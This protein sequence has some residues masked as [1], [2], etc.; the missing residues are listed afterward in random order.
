MRKILL[1]M[2]FL[3]GMLMY[4]LPTIAQEKNVSGTV[5]DNDDNTALR[6]VTVTVKGT[7][8]ATK[9]NQE[10]FYNIQASKGQVLVFTFIGYARKELTVGD[11]SILNATLSQSDKALSEVV[12]TAYGIKKEKA[13]LSYSTV[14]IKGEDIA[15]T[16]RENF[17]NSLAGRVPGATITSTSGAPGASAQIILRG[18]VSIDGDN[19]PLFVVDG[20]PYDNQSL[21]QESLVPASN[22]NGIGFANRN[23]DYGN[24]A[25]DINPD[26]IENVTI[27]KGP[28]ATALYGAAGASGVIIITTKK[29]AKGKGSI[30]Y[31]NT[32][33]YEKVYRFPE[34]QTNFGRGRNGVSDPTSSYYFGPKYDDGTQL[35]DNFGAFLKTGITQ[36]HNLSIE[37]GSDVNTFRFSTGYTKQDGVIPTSAFE[38]LSFR[39]SGSSKL[40]PKLNIS[41]TANYVNSVTDK[42]SKGLGSYFLTLLSWPKDNDVRDYLNSDGSRK[43]LKGGNTLSETDNPF[44]DVNKNLANDRTDRFTFN[45]TISYDVLSWLNLTSNIGADVYSTQ[46]IYSTNPQSRY[47][48]ATNGFMS[49]YTQNTRNLSGNV[50]AGVKKNFDHISNSLIVGFNFDDNRTRIESQK[51]E[52]FIEPDFLS[53]NNVAPLTVSSKTTVLNFKR[54]RWF[55]S[56]TAGYDKI[57]YVTL[58]GS[59]EG[60]SRLTSKFYQKSPYFKYGAAS[61]AFNFTELEPFKNISWLTN[62]KLRAGYSTTGK[63][64]YSPYIIDYGFGSVITTGGGYALGVTGGNENLKPELT[65][66][67]EFGGELKF[68]K[69]RL[70]LDVSYYSLRSKDQILAVRSSYGTGY[71]L[72]Y[73][74]GGLV[75]NK[76]MEIVLKGTPVQSKNLN[77]DVTVNYSFNR[78]KII[79]MP[80]DVPQ[81]YNSDT[82][83]YG[84]ARSIAYAGGKLGNISTDDFQRNKKGDVLISTTTGLPLKETTAALFKNITGN[85]EPKGSIGFINSITYKNFNL[86]FNLDVRIGGDIYNGNELYLYNLGLSKKTLNRESAVV[87][88]GVLADGLENTANPTVNTIAIQPAYRNDYYITNYIEA[89]FIEKDINWLR[90]R[91]ITLSYRVPSDFLKGQK[92][93]R[94]ASVFVTGTDVFMLTNYSGADPNV[95]GLTGGARG[96]GGGGFDFGALANP[97]G[98]SFGLKAQ[99]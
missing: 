4:S 5:M 53:I 24:R 91:D 96:Y 12:V 14:E 49:Q 64:P 11:G 15:Q 54:V 82:W 25:M 33:R 51:G 31:D 38:R 68:F 98:I 60:D 37:G 28:E 88:K 63:A 30:T 47:G 27:L 45:N 26:D 29:G 40:T 89:E 13:S 44:W 7:N 34:I 93:V 95:S 59:I 58:A 41:S 90:L 56:Y 87:V 69:N 77:W 94:S 2:F 21:N 61:F 84:N 22:P 67:L 1:L 6:D 9:T 55:G 3:G 10:G 81:F 76:G 97:R 19:Q 43:I 73:I 74:N 79:S 8:R 80:G 85:R 42:V 83:L 23:S 20:V 75:Q 17:L 99:F 65:R 71:V 92:I 16:K 39:L 57:L 46:G 78:G 70:G 50:R 18:A 66:Q 36:K 48:A 52:Q 35:Y 62:G 32:F 72:K 86:N